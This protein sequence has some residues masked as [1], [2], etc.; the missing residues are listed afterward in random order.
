M[1]FK[2]IIGKETKSNM[3][4]L[5]TF[6]R[7]E[8][9]KDVNSQPSWEVDKNVVYVTSLL[10]CPLLSYFER[11]TP[12]KPVGDSIWYFWRGTLID[13]KITEK[14]RKNQISVKKRVPKEI[15]NEI[16]PEIIK[17][18]KER[19]DTEEV[20]IRGRAD[21]ID[22]DTIYELKSI[23]NMY[24][25]AKPKENHVKQ[26]M[27]YYW[28][29]KN[30]SD[31]HKNINKAVLLYVDLSGFLPF[32]IIMTDEELEDNAN[33][34]FYKAA[35]TLKANLLNEPP[36]GERTYLCKMC[37]FSKE[38]KKAQKEITDRINIEKKKEEF[39]FVEE[40]KKKIETKEPKKEAIKNVIKK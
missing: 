7:E 26:L 14:F 29:L 9:T 30:F 33:E 15:L 36:L 13:K 4:S 16:S 28:V 5:P 31:E 39:G 6:L 18:L 20:W 37:N 32:E 23:A 21:F 38:C 19:E 8:I 2:K 12:R 35:E 1:K 40:P 11:K 25:L 34:F 3:E 10:I 22:E 17:I 24:Y 27:F